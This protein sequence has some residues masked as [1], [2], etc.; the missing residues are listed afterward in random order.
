MHIYIYIHIHTYAYIYIYIRVSCPNQGD[1]VAYLRSPSL[2]FGDC[3]HT[4]ISDLSAYPKGPPTRF[5]LRPD[6]RWRFPESEIG[7]CPYF[8]LL[9]II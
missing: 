9:N 5:K 8:I 3:F 7:T 6:S 2:D 1:P 4:S